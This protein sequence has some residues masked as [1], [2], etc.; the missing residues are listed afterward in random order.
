MK[1][2]KDEWLL[3]GGSYKNDPSIL[4]IYGGSGGQVM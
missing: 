4:G 2:S 1:L 3:P